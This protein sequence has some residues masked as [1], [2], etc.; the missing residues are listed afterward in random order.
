[1]RHPLAIA[2]LAALAFSSLS[3]CVAALVPVGAAALMGKKELDRRTAYK[4]NPKLAAKGA[5]AA[6]TTSAADQY[7]TKEMTKGGSVDYSIASQAAFDPRAAAVPPISDAPPAAGAAFD[8]RMPDTA[9]RVGEYFATKVKPGT[10][11]TSGSVVMSPFGSLTKPDF[12]VCENMAPTLLVDLDGGTETSVPVNDAII[13][14]FD[15]VRDH[16]GK[17]VFVASVPEKDANMLA[18]DLVVAGLGPAKRGDTLYLIGDRGSASKDAL[19][20]RIASSNCVVAMVGD[21]YEDFSDQ[22]SAGVLANKD[23]VGE[24]IRKL[25]GAGWFILPELRA[26]DTGGKP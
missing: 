7:I 26:A 5:K 3:G 23:A 9:V 21:R 11:P 22:L 8:M 25:A 19:R 12:T 20:W 4:R 13:D 10:K 6:T 17:V 16:G 15:Q 1:M 14:L 24:S 2:A 18:T